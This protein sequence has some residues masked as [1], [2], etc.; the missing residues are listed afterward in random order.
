MSGTWWKM[1]KPVHNAILRVPYVLLLRGR[2]AHVPITWGTV[3]GPENVFRERNDHIGYTCGKSD[4]V[5]M[6]R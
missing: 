1:N 6:R 3:G 4:L 2:V 5:R